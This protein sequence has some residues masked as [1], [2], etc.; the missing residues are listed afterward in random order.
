MKSCF[1][2]IFLLISTISFSQKKINKKFQPLAND[3]N[4]Y[5]NGLDD[6]I[7]ENSNSN[8][9]EVY[10]EAESYDNQI[11]K[12]EE[13]NSELNINFHFEGAE[14]REVIF[15]KY[16][17]KRLQRASVIVKI[18]KGKKVIVF[19]ENIDIESKNL[20]NE[21]GIYIE[22]GIVKL[23]VIQLNTI[24]KLYSGNIYA[25]TRNINLDLKSNTG[26]IKV[27]SIFYLRKYKKK[28][29][30]TKNLFSITSIKGNIFLNSD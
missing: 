19:G 29:R 8:F 20:K 10:L 7:L 25:S 5:T 23:N 22:N 17:T 26:K 28:S 21:L 4:I 13:T 1:L 14:T 30:T 11:I 15:R 16:I 6:I 12:I 24:L 9:V 2:L 18:P 27:D 3:I